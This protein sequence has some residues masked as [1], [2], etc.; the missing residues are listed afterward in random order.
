[1]TTVYK[2]TSFGRSTDAEG[3][4][5]LRYKL[6]QTTYPAQGT[7]WVMACKALEE[8]QLY[9]IGYRDV[10]IW[11]CEAELLEGDGDLVSSNTSNHSIACWWR[12]YAQVNGAIDEALLPL[13]MNAMRM[14]WGGVKCAWIKPIRKVSE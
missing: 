3:V 6:G 9:R 14:C 7:K 5:S 2:V 11:E 10:E 12:H 13:G 1:M 8:A 4:Y